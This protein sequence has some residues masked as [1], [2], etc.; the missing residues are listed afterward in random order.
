M[1]FIGGAA[2]KGDPLGISTAG[3]LRRPATCPIPVNAPASCPDVDLY[4]EDKAKRKGG[5]Q[6]LSYL[7]TIGMPRAR[8]CWW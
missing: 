2:G 5:Y 7:R 6:P 3:P 4:I 8:A 1:T